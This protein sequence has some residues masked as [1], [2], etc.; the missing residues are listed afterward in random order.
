[1][2]RPDAGGRRAPA[3][4]RST[5]SGAP[6]AAALLALASACYAV[7]PSHGG[8]QAD[9]DGPRAVRASDVAVP[10]GYRI[11]VV[12]TGLRFPTGVAFDAQGR[13]CV[14]E[15]GYAYGEVFATPRLVRVEP[16]GSLATIAEGRDNGP[17]TG[18][19]FDG[20][21]FFV[22]EG[23]VREGGRIL[24]IGADGAIDVLVEDLP[25]RGDHHT[26]GPAIGPDGKLYFGVGTATNSGVV[27]EDNAKFGWL[28]RFPEFHD[29]PGADVRLA[30][31]DF[32]T[33]DVAGRETAVTG[34]FVPFGTRTEKGQ[35]I[36]GSNRCTGSVLRIARGGGEPELVA[37]GFRN[38]FGLAF[39]PAGELFVTDNGY[40]VRGSRPVWGAGDLLW[41]VE[42]G[43]WYG[44]PDFSGGQ[45]V[46]RE[47]FDP[48]GSPAP[49]FLLAEHPN[50]PPAPVASFACHASADG[51]DF[52]RDPA[53]GFVGDAFVAEFGD[54]VP[55][56]SKVLAPVGFKVV[57]VEIASG[58][59]EDFATNRGERNGPASWL[60]RRGLER[61]V[62]VRFDPSGRALYVVDFGVLTQTGDQAR[63]RIGTGVLWRITRAAAPATAEV[64]R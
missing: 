40:D 63:P 19:V 57:R 31:R 37:W 33:R 42:Q 61:P 24:R 16:D 10:P 54:Q 48:P 29:V 55:V 1:M 28:A 12:A 60:G 8:A 45:P 20:G 18:V 22:A 51:L 32:T 13:P 36:R 9:F 21:E 56:T 50:A 17:W 14:V 30:G 43:R 27:G 34:A 23:G 6:L 35:V 7:R 44:W 52:A 3:R 62:A 26:N 47:A 58:V 25:S 59:I 15:S 41:K 53:F 4:A 49:E 38:P 2:K 64:R 39:S 5:S 46:T 11:E